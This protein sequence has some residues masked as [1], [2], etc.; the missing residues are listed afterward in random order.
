[1]HGSLITFEG[2]DGC[3]KSTASKAAFNWGK[4]NLPF[5]PIHTRQ[6]GGTAAGEAIRDLLLHPVVPIPTETEL[7]LFCASFAASCQTLLL[8]E[9]LGGKWMFC[10][11]YTD[12][13]RAYQG[14]GRGL[15]PSR[16]ETLLKVAVEYH[17]VLVPKKTFLLDISPK[18]AAER[19]S[20]SRTNAGKDP[21]EKEGLAF[22]SR[23][24]KRFLEIAEANPQRFVV[25]NSERISP[26]EVAETVTETLNALKKTG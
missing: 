17:P 19:I 5:E 9:L 6:P 26:E 24:R 13:T 8:P 14:A 11:R 1:M 16:I 15:D 12:S 2:I 22:Q 7:L 3:G 4:K 25:L 18:V 20:A 21:F 23:I 10:D